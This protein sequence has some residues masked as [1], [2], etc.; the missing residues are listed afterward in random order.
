MKQKIKFF[1]FLSLILI[2]LVGCVPYLG[3]ESSTKEAS[4]KELDLYYEAIQ[5]NDTALCFKLDYKSEKRRKLA[6]DYEDHSFLLRNNC[7]REIAR[8]IN[9]PNL[10]NELTDVNKFGDDFK[11]VI[12][13]CKEE[14]T[15]LR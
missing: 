14:A 10:C 6:W 9:N 2:L 11:Y 13:A 8:K 5:S 15:D 3:L 7:F 1:I 12:E 4:K